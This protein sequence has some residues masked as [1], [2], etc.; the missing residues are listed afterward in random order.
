M[1]L[2][3]SRS[4]LSLQGVRLGDRHFSGSLGKLDLEVPRRSAALL[5]V[6]DDSDAAVLVDACLGLSDPSTG[7]VRFLGVD[8]ATRT[9]AERMYRRRRIGTVV[10]TDVWPVHMT[11]LDSVLLAGAYHFDR[12]REEVI[13]H[14]TELCRLF[15][16]P[17]LPTGR[18]ETTPRRALVR[19]AC[20]RGFL[21]SPDLIVMQDAALEQSTELAVPLAQAIS[22]AR[23]RGAAV[24]WV[25]ASLAAQAAAFVEAEQVLRLGEH[26]IARTRRGR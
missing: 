25:T 14:A 21:G 5:Q 16:L 12:P 26:G 4:V 7:H 8:W 18:R 15:G 3:P 9:P 13:E 23:D 10:Q 1:A 11:V 17:G 2:R 22:S 20:V 19:A 24:L 6:D